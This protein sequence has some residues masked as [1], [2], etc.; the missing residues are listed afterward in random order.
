MILIPFSWFLVRNTLLSIENANPD[1]PETERTP[2]YNYVS[3]R[4]NPIN[5]KTF[6]QYN[7]FYGMQVPSTHVMWYYMLFLNRY[8]FMHNICVI[9]LH[10]IPGAIADLALLLSARKP[11]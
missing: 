5:W 10:I 2:I 8:L 1:V 6:M 9:F 11:M 7:E 3:S 4:R